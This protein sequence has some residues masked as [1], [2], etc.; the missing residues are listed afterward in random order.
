MSNLQSLE[1]KGLNAKKHQRDTTAEESSPNTNEAGNSLASLQQQ[2]GNRA[3]QRL[4]VQRSGEGSFEVNDDTA[5]R[6]NRERASG[7]ALDSN[8]QTKMSDATGQDFSGVRVHTGSESNALNE[9]LHAK[10]FT[11]GQDIYFREG[12][13]DPGSTS[14]QELLAHELTHVVQQSSGRVGSGSGRMSVNAP[15]DAFEQEADSVAKS[16]MSSGAT[17]E[18]QR[19][20]DEEDEIQTMSLQRQETDEEKEEDE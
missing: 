7:Q 17:P 18:V 15:G 11:T 16:V 8:V 10:A 2:V 13:Y 20:T 12:A 3:V 6:I 19:A 4:L 1:E 5:N 9:S 14:G